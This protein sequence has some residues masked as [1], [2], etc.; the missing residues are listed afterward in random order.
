MPRVALTPRE[1][2][3]LALVAKG[4]SNREIATVIGR[5]E[6]TVKVHMKN[7][8]AKLAVDD[9]T[10]AVRIVGMKRPVRT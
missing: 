6:T 4:L 3:V 9:R 2:E 10:G 5:E 7:I 1:L 8:T